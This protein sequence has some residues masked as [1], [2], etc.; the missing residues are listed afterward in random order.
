[1]NLLLAA[2][3]GDA[4]ARRS[5]TSLD[6]SYHQ[7]YREWYQDFSRVQ[8]QAQNEWTVGRSQGLEEGHKQGFMEGL[9]E[10]H[11][12]SFQAGVQEGRR[13]GL[14]EGRSQG[15]EEGHKKGY[16]EGFASGWTIASGSRRP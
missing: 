12:L 15:L 11:R 3:R 6:P 14:D 16:A 5:I 2:T 4:D 7:G 8:G 13:Q 10:G 9:Q 1:M